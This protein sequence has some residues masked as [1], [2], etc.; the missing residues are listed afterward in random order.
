MFFSMAGGNVDVSTGTIPE[1]EDQ[2]WISFTYLL[3][4]VHIQTLGQN[5]LSSIWQMFHQ[6]MWFLTKLDL[7]EF[8]NC[9]KKQVV[10]LSIQ[11]PL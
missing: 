7:V 8:C 3:K 1:S 9:Q 2:F 10:Y 11:K 4:T 5:P 6:V